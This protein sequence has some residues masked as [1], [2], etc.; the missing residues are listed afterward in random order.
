MWY[1]SVL[2]TLVACATGEDN[3]YAA[4]GL[5]SSASARDIRVA[6][7]SFV[8][9]NHP[10]ISEDGDY[11][12]FIKTHAI[13][14]V[15]NDAS[16]RHVYD[17]AGETIELDYNIEI[18]SVQEY[19]RSGEFDDTPEVMVLDF[20]KWASL[21]GNE[22][23]FMI[24]FTS[25]SLPQAAEIASAW[26]VFAREVHD[27]L[28]VAVVDCDSL[29]SMYLCDHFG[30]A[31]IPMI[32]AIGWH[33]PKDLKRLENFYLDYSLAN[34]RTFSLNTVSS[35][36]YPQREGQ[37]LKHVRPLVLNMNRGSFSKESADY[38]VAIN[39]DKPWIVSLCVSS[40]PDACGSV[41]VNLNQMAVAGGEGMGYGLVDCKRL[42]DFCVNKFRVTVTPSEFGDDSVKKRDEFRY[43]LLK[44]LDG[45]PTE[46]TP[47]SHRGSDVYYAAQQTIGHIFE[48]V[49]VEELERVAAN[50]M[51]DPE[52]ENP[53]TAR[54]K[55]NSI[56]VQVK[57][58]MELLVAFYSESDPWCTEPARGPYSLNGCDRAKRMLMQLDI[59]YINVWADT[60]PIQ[61]RKFDCTK[62]A[63]SAD[64]CKRLDVGQ[65][66]GTMPIM[67]L[68][69]KAMNPHWYHG[70][71]DRTDTLMQFVLTNH[72]SELHEIEAGDFQR[73]VVR[74]KETWFVMFYAPW[75]STCHKLPHEIAQLS[76]HPDVTA[77][78]KKK[79]KYFTSGKM[80][81]QENAE[82][83]HAL[84][85]K[86]YPTLLFFD[87]GVRHQF[88]YDHQN[89]QEFVRFVQHTWRPLVHE[90]T[91]T[92]FGE[93]IEGEEHLA[94][95]GTTQGEVKD[96]GWVIHFFEPPK[97][98]GDLNLTPVFEGASKALKGVVKFG[99]L[100]C[101]LE[102]EFCQKIGVTEYPTLKKYTHEEQGPHFVEFFD[103]A[104]ASLMKLLDFSL[105]DVNDYVVPFTNAKDF[106]ARVVDTKFLN[107][108][109]VIFFHN[110]KCEKCDEMAMQ[111]K[112]L[113]SRWRV[114]DAQLERQEA[115]RQKQMG[116][117][118]PTNTHKGIRL[119][120]G[121]VNC[122]KMATLCMKKK[123]KKYPAL[124]YFSKYRQ[125]NIKFGKAHGATDEAHENIV[126]IMSFVNEQEE[127]D[128]LVWRSPKVHGIDQKPYE[129]SF[130]HESKIKIE[131]Y[132]N[133]L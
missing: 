124:V 52:D 132:H 107:E 59:D 22:E 35:V 2:A 20:E 133:E 16:K 87:E 70:E 47:A 106:Q 48:E 131:R 128:R 41:P 99:K 94:T 56:I 62:D 129:Y 114:H 112:G 7:S 26:K 104:H 50:A 13:F 17:T 45:T 54:S 74:N 78:M 66:P 123:V 31:T 113:A 117:E 92:E 10:E 40:G 125:K 34:F 83:C 36:Y 89:V 57:E 118:N 29:G 27:W 67:L 100:N 69:Y 81:C 51:A 30:V 95:L 72:N 25:A 23:A 77:I 98:E 19:D 49:S 61:L 46:L 43:F 37:Q 110:D 122:K 101:E 96:I 86:H 5:D 75:C 24:L 11:N 4:L 90:F 64:L 21:G 80:N 85:I 32:D 55:R 60:Y 93:T 42:T 120:V 91:V 12:K 76:V 71:L 15:L 73:S 84:G 6:W 38:E 68:K 3:F 65:A 103:P 119:M 58:R 102:R 28:R 127:A 79:E 82:L 108:P 63:A 116:V 109:W 8:K 115:R 18:K 39:W 126:A 1:L 121:S 14:N 88:D 97:E 33:V 9:G 130:L 105:R 53:Y 44:S 111:M